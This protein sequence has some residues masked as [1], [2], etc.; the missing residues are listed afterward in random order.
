MTSKLG[1]LHNLDTLLQAFLPSGRKIALCTKNSWGVM[2]TADMDNSKPSH[3]I[4]FA[5]H[6]PLQLHSLKRPTLHL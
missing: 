2:P 3:Q 1:S 5:R 6:R 4:F